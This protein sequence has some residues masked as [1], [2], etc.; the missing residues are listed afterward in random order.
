[1]HSR[2][3]SPADRYGWSPNMRIRNVFQTCSEHVRVRT[4]PNMFGI[5]RVRTLSKTYRTLSE[6]LFAPRRDHLPK[7]ED[8]AETRPPRAHCHSRTTTH[9]RCLVARTHTFLPKTFSAGC[10]R[11]RVGS[12]RSLGWWQGRRIR[13]A[14]G[15]MS[16]ITQLP[17]WRSR[18]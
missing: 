10:R 16:G 9:N 8:A 11:K 4:C 14:D 17:S 15:D 2:P 1:M 6:H 13:S 18:K 7:A 3:N 5:V 12:N